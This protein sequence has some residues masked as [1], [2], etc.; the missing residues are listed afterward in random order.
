MTR[1]KRIAVGIA[2]FCLF[3]GYQRIASAQSVASSFGELDGKLKAGMT[4]YVTDNAGGKIKGKVT[5]LS[6][7]SLELSAK[8]NRQSF[9]ENRVLQITEQRRSVGK[10]AK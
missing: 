4:V 3:S 2:C 7:S 5:D 10:G 6:A 9:P 8:G 1:H